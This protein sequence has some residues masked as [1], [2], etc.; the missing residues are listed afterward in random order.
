RHHRWLIVGD[1][2]TGYTLSAIPVDRALEARLPSRSREIFEILRE[3]GQLGTGEIAD[4]LDMARPS[5]IRRLK[6]LQEAE[7][8]EWSGNGPKDPRA[9]WK[10][11]W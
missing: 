10:I 2:R 1:S 9:Y 11:R 7:L 4:A 8:I 6:A 3:A 5:V